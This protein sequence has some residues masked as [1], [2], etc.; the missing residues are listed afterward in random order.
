M[1]RP[2]ALLL[3][4]L[5]WLVPVWADTI[6]DVHFDTPAQMER[7]KTL[8][9]ELRCPKCLNSNLAGSDAPIAADLRAEI[10]EQIAAGNND[11]QILDYLTTR[12]G[13]FILYKPPLH[14]GTSFLWFGPLGLLLLGF[15]VLRRMLAASRQLVAASEPL[16]KQ[17]QDQLQQMLQKDQ[18][19]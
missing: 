2:I 5:L 9:A 16:S 14:I 15:F 11:Q 4:N 18:Q 6:E 19:G 10:R 7:Y 17:E 1:L 3:V 13:E 12:Y 8:I